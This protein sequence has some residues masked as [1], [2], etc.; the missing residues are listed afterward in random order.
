M[1]TIDSFEDSVEPIDEAINN[2]SLPVLFGRTEPLSDELR[3]L[4]TL[5]PA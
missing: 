2:N 4:F 3:E 1:Q 5:P